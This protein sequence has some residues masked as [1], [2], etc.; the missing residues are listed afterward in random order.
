M[1][2]DGEIIDLYMYL[3]KKQ[4]CWGLKSLEF[5]DVK[6]VLQLTAATWVNQINTEYFTW[7]QTQHM[8]TRG[9]DQLRG[10]MCDWH[11]LHR[12]WTLP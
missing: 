10:Y 5:I 11:A 12:S 9:Q 4:A 8:K 6:T 1:K 3:C 7:Y 2:L